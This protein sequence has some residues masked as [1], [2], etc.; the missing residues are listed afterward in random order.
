M[1]GIEI[2]TNLGYLD[3]TVLNG[4][5]GAIMVPLDSVLDDIV[6]GWR[7]DEETWNAFVKCAK[8]KEK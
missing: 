6:P 7:E 4:E 8:Y 5:I 3:D 1:N 2:I